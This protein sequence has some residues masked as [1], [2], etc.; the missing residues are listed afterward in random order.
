MGEHV[1]PISM[2]LLGHAREYIGGLN[3]YRYAGTLDSSAAET[4]RD[5]WIRVFLAA[6][7]DAVAEARRFTDEI[8]QMRKSWDRKLAIVQVKEVERGARAYVS[9]DVLDLINGAER[10]LTY[11]SGSCPS[12]ALAIDRTLILAHPDH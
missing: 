4:G 2:S 10:R 7:R 9:T 5:T 1:L 12:R 3:A 11:R 8:V 6:T